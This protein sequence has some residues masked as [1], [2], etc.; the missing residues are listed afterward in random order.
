MLLVSRPL[1]EYAPLWE[2]RISYSIHVS[3]PILNQTIAVYTMCS[4]IHCNA[5]IVL[6]RGTYYC[7]A[8]G[9]FGRYTAWCR[10]L[11]GFYSCEKRNSRGF[12]LQGRGRCQ[13]LCGQEAASGLRQKLHALCY[14]FAQ[15]LQGVFSV[16]WHILSPTAQITH[17]GQLKLNNHIFCAL[18]VKLLHCAYVA[19]V[20]FVNL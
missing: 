7:R 12:V 14:L 5:V 11:S 18:D 8:N 17:F 15:I 19:R 4:R 1:Y 6:Q 10:P 2:P 16:N 13:S 9:V 20:L 3:E